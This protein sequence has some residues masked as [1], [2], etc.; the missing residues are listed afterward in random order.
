MLVTCSNNF[1]LVFG[2]SLR[3]AGPPAALRSH[4]ES[5]AM[6]PGFAGDPAERRH[7][8]P[9]EESGSYKPPM[10]TIFGDSL[11]FLVI[12]IMMNYP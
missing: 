9:G 5:A 6:P 11:Y 7:S 1:R 10:K 8:L 2:V 3:A 4:P 12:T